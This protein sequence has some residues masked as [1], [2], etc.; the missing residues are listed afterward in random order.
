MEVN[1]MRQ[2]IR[3]LKYTKPYLFHLLFGFGL[4]ILLA[5]QSLLMPLFQRFVI[6]NILSHATD[7]LASIDL[8]FQSDL[9]GGGEVSNALRGQLEG[10]GILLSSDAVVSIEEAGR[11]WRITDAANEQKYIVGRRTF[12]IK[13]DYQSDLA[14][15]GAISV[16]LRK[17]FKSK[18]IQLSPGATV[19]V[20]AEQGTWLIVDG[21]KHYVIWKEDRKLKGHEGELKI[22]RSG[23]T[24]T[25]LG[26]EFTYSAFGWLAIILCT[27][28]TVFASFAILKA[29]RTYVMSWVSMRV[30]FDIRTH[31]FS[32]MQKLSM[33][34]YDVQGTGQILSRVK[35][36]VSALSRLVTDTTLNIVTDVI[37]IIVMLAIMFTWSWK[38]SLVALIALPLITGNYFYFIGKKRRLWRILRHKWADITTTLTEA[39]AGAKVVKAFHRE[40]YQERRVFR[41]IRQTL[42]LQLKLAKYRTEEEN[43]AG[44]IRMFGKGAVLTYGGYLVT[45]DELTIG[46]LIAFHQFVNRIFM[47]V[48]GLLRVNMK[49]QKAMVSVERVFGLL[50]SKPGVE[51]APDAVDLPEIQGHVQFENVS[52]SYDPEN[53][54]L[55]N[56]N[57]EAKPNMM[58]ALVGPSGCGKS[59]ISNLIERFY[60]PTEGAVRI[61]GHDLR[62]VTLKSLRDQMGVVL[63]DNFLFEGSISENIRFGRLNASDEEVVQAAVA[64]NAHNFIVEQLPEGYETEVGERG[65]RLSGGQKQRIAIARTILRDPQVLI[66]DEAT[67]ALD[68][69]SEAQIQQA[70]DRLM[71]GRTSFVI[72]HRLS[73]ILKADTIVAMK[74]GRIVEMGTHKELVAAGGIYAGMYKK[75]FK[76][77]QE[78]TSQGE[79]PL[80]GKTKNHEKKS[81][82]AAMGGFGDFQFDGLLVHADCSK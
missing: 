47:P 20:E 76:I 30:S 79:K 43:I 39:I 58:V 42:G 18:G 27:I 14:D 34:F 78:A 46:T 22:Y 15:G 26:R 81:A 64:A 74:E 49:I 6:R 28:V 2:L 68:S 53:P 41:Y 77:E 54:V 9:E 52:F 38:L 82:T 12:Q 24:H 17:H 72:A 1:A 66:L 7:P 31:V 61:D 36:D 48:M 62:D 67:S 56:V 80:E 19:S 69:E 4:M 70:L 21:E 50:D 40:R 32:H 23:I 45:Q 35:E 5:Q 63:Q 25:F 59:T 71:E 65:L 55:H 13:S 75:Q 37:A 11:K 33:R 16:D 57:I 51:E 10:K 29:I 60:D 44:F 73:T 3:I 8:A